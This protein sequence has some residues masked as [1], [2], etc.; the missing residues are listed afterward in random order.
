[1]CLYIADFI[2]TKKLNAEGLADIN[3]GLS[4][5]LDDSTKADV[6][7]LLTTSGIPAPPM[8]NILP[9]LPVMALANAMSAFRKAVPTPPVQKVLPPLPPGANKNVPAPAPPAA[10]VSLFMQRLALLK[11]RIPKPPPGPAIP[12]PPVPTTDLKVLGEYMEKTKKVSSAVDFFNK[13]SSVVEVKSSIKK[14]PE[15]PKLTMMEKI[16]LMKANADKML[17]KLYYFN[18]RGRAEPIRMMLHHAGVKWE[19][20]RISP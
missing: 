20:V 17:T 19:D 18:A 15:A 12:P 8:A 9:P 16:A 7:A 10:P 11:S 6:T 14:V 13:R 2:P 1:M 5:S 4:V 3:A